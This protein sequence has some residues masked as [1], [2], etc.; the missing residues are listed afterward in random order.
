MGLIHFR[1]T[2]SPRQRM[3]ANVEIGLCTPRPFVL[4]FGAGRFACFGQPGQGRIVLHRRGPEFAVQR[5]ALL[6]NWARRSS[7]AVT[8]CDGRRRLAGLGVGGRVMPDRFLPLAIRA[9]ISLTADWRWDSVR[10]GRPIARSIPATGCG[11]KS[12][13]WRPAEDRPQACRRSGEDHRPR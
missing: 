5:R 6:M 12:D 13:R 7:A 9:C 4:L 8:S 3:T 2:F 10:R 1:S 11:A